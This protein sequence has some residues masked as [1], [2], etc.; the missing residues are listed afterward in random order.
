[1]FDGLRHPGKGYRAAG[2]RL[3]S[4]GGESEGVGDGNIAFIAYQPHRSD[5]GKAGAQPVLEAGQAAHGALG[6][7]AADHRLHCSFAAPQVGTA[8]CS[9]S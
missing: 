9:N 4:E 7:V 1:V 6:F 3:Q 8:Q 2:L 5:V